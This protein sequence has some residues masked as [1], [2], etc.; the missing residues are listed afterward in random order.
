ML[1]ILYIENEAELYPYLRKLFSCFNKRNSPSKGVHSFLYDSAY[2]INTYR[3]Y[4]WNIFIVMYCI[5]VLVNYNIYFRLTKTHYAV[6]DMNTTD[7]TYTKKKVELL[8]S[9]NFS[10]RYRL[11]TEIWSR[12]CMRTNCIYLAL[13]VC[14]CNYLMTCLKYQIFLELLP[15]KAILYGFKQIIICWRCRSSREIYN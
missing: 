12:I 14:C 4:S 1:E 10:M 5:K 11:Q 8:H 6:D 15:S 9:S 13:K 7:G 3:T 2:C